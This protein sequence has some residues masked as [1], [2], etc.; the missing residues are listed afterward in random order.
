MIM[1]EQICIL[2]LLHGNGEKNKFWKCM[3]L[4]SSTIVILSGFYLLKI[5]IYKTIILCIVLYSCRVWFCTLREEHTF[6][7]V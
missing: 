2:W 1:V 7:S 6:T 4:L 3:L 5:K